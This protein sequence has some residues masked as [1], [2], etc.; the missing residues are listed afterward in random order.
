MQEMEYQSIE[1]LSNGVLEPFMRGQHVV[2]LI[3]G[4]WK[5]IWNDMDLELACTKIGKGTRSIIRKKKLT[6]DQ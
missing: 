4:I 5:R 6:P 1:R 3:R 2:H